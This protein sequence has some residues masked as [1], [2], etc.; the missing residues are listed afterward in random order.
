[1]ITRA[2]AKLLGNY[3]F[4]KKSIIESAQLKLYYGNN[5]IKRLPLRATKSQL[6]KTILRIQSETKELYNDE[7][8][9]ETKCPYYIV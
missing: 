3:S 1:M 7:K 8:I 4:I 6:Q 9:E 5:K 2:I